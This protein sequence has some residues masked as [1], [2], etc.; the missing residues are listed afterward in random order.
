MSSDTSAW[1]EVLRQLRAA[2]PDIT[3]AVLVTPDGFPIAADA[4][5]ELNTDL[6]AALAADLMARANRS[7]REFRQ[8]ELNEIYAHGTAGY[9]IVARA[10]SGEMLAC[11]AAGSATLGLLLIDVRRTVA[12]LGSSQPTSAASQPSPQV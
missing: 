3:A 6:L 8:G 2:N 5:P 7:A 11:L 9:V 4:V 10:S 12:Q 1:A